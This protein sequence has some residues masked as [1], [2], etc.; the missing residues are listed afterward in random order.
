MTQEPNTAGVRAPLPEQHRVE[1]LRGL[2]VGIAHEF[3]NALTAIGG[4]AYLLQSAGSADAQSHE[5][6]REIQK[7]TEE[8]AFLARELMTFAST[9]VD[10]PSRR[11]LGDIV[12]QLRRVLPHVLPPKIRIVERLAAADT[13]V[14]ADPQQITE[15]A[16]ALTVHTRQ[17]LAAGGD[18]LVATRYT[19]L[20]DA[21]AAPAGVQPGSYGVVEITTADPAAERH[22]SSESTHTLVTDAERV[23]SAAGG[24]LALHEHGNEHRTFSMFLP[25]APAGDTPSAR[26]RRPGTGNETILLLEDDKELADVIARMLQTRGYQVLRAADGDVA[27]GLAGTFGGPIH[28]LLA[29]IIVPGTMGLDL[30]RRFTAIQPGARVLFMSGYVHGLGDDVHLL[31]KPFEADTLARTVR[32][33]LDEPRG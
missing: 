9:G 14:W 33:V 23:L 4:I 1:A 28:L 31:L 2:A 21:N 18:L 10:Q 22:A 15:I 11:R 8:A 24:A 29:D 6:L 13:E 19:E 30:L 25:C 26:Q 20:D 17:H 3:A 7:I 5:D 16:L 12:K 32:E 27:L